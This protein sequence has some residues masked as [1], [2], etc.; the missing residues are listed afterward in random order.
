MPVQRCQRRGK[1]GNRW[2][3]SG[4]CFIG[5]GSRARA[6]RQGRAIRA[7]G[8]TGNR[9]EVVPSNPL[10]ADPTRSIT[11]RRIFVADFW[12]RFQALKGKILRLIVD[13]DAFGIKQTRN[14]E[15]DDER[16]LYG[17][18]DRT[19]KTERA[20]RR[21]REANRGTGETNG[22]TETV[23]S[24]GSAANADRS[25]R[26]NIPV[27]RSVRTINA[28]RWEFRSDPEKV[29][30]FELWLAKEIQD[31][32]VTVTR[33]K[34]SDAYWQKYVQ[35]GYRKG[36]GRAFTDVK[37]PAL[38]SGR[39]SLSFFEGTQEEFLRAS[40]GRPVATN[41]VKLLAGRVFT[42]L[43]GVT[44]TMSTQM[45]RV[46][47]DGLTQGQGPRVIAD[48]LNDRVAKIGQH[49]ATLIA[50]TEITR[51][52]AE[53]Q[54]DAME[55]LGVKTVGV[56]VEWSTAGD[57]RVCPLCQPLEGVVMTIKEAR[58]LIPRHAICR[59]A[60]VP[61]QVGEDPTEKTRVNF[62]NPRTKK[63][64]VKH[65]PQ[66]RGKFKLDRARDKS[67]AAEIP[68]RS[69]RTV[70][71]QKALSRWKGADTTFR[72]KRPKSI[73]TKGAT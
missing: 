53:G 51:A 31:V 45:S 24:N 10:K 25:G 16:Q 49:R 23:L 22:G 9:T 66:Q 57:D 27:G 5:R 60:F 39:E 61:A 67:I 36:A 3:R 58:G 72:R 28:G 26:G 44:Q 33:S 2:G 34:V 69:R 15:R 43:K 64:E 50:R 62:T 4:K 48:A 1:R 11:L 71:Q 54:L 40:F 38:A 47:A 37:G 42:D 70:A 12:N 29:K 14:E 55:S 30:A 63:V 35:A 32:I 41:K 65:L 21:T 13:E 18:N 68:K 59:C 73:L 6:A 20:G 56:M 46:L 17:A 52:H 8:F 19:Q 7:A